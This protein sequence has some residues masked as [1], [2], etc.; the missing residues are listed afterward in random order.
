MWDQKSAKQFGEVVRKLRA[1]ADISQETLAGR[2][3][4]TKN[5]IQ[6]IEAGKS[7]GLA[8]ETRPSNPRLSTLCG[9]A[10]AFD[11]SVAKLL[12]AAEL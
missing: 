3:G 6:L 10:D 2:A 8:N 1:E 12:E 5:Q 9:L 4:I 11:I 7:T